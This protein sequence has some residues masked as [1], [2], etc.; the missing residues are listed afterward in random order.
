MSVKLYLCSKLRKIYLAYSDDTCLVLTTFNIIERSKAIP[1]CQISPCAEIACV[2]FEQVA[3]GEA[4]W[5]A[6]WGQLGSST[7][8]RLPDVLQEAGVNILGLDYCREHVKTDLLHYEGYQN[9][10]K[11][12]IC[13]GKPDLNDDG[14]LDGG[15]DTCQG[16]CRK[17][18]NFSCYLL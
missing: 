9:L 17:F 6:G 15:V 12:E 16:I 18:A 8:S 2:P 11:G 4:C 10:Q 14:V 5:I 7:Y 3:D 13:A 1:E